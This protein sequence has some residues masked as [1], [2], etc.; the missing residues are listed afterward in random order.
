MPR[1]RP[2][3]KKSTSILPRLLVIT[4]LAAL[5]VGAFLQFSPDSGD[6]ARELAALESAVAPVRSAFAESGTTVEVTGP[7]TVTI[8]L[9]H[10]EAMAV[11]EREAM[12]LARTARERIGP[13]ITVR[14]K[15]PAGQNLAVANP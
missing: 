15:S 7:A 11:G 1:P 6:Q 14:V 13:G 9:P 2:V 4:P 3:S 10:D 8:T 12:E 5:A